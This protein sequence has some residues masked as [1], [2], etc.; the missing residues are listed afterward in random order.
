[1][2]SLRRM[3]LKTLTKRSKKSESRF[4]RL[5]RRP[6]KCEACE[7]LVNSSYFRPN[8]GWLRPAFS[9]ALQTVFS[10]KNTWKVMLLRY[11]SNSQGTCHA[12]PKAKL[13]MEK[14]RLAILGQGVYDQFKGPK[15]NSKTRSGTVGSK[16]R[17]SWNN[18]GISSC[19]AQ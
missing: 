14:G 7:R 5:R 15:I 11:K 4:R 19:F 13:D 9:S 2:K 3:P 1:M 12:G 16:E 18:S 17:S 8:T 10:L 6:E